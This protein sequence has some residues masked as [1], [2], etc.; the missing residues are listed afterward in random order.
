MN[1][2]FLIYALVDPD[3]KLP[4]YIG[5]S[6]SGLKRPQHYFSTAV[7]K[8][9]TSHK[10]NWI[11]SLFR[12]GKKPIV[13]VLEY[14]ECSSELNDAECFWIAQGRGIGW[15]LTNLTKGGEGLYGASTE[16]REKIRRKMKNRFIS[17]EHR[18]RISAGQ[19][20]KT[21][22]EETRKKSSQSHM[23]KSPSPETR[24]KLRRAFLGRTLSPKAL[25][26]ARTGQK[27]IKRSPG[28]REKIS[29]ALRLRVYSEA[30]REKRRQ[31]ALAQW[32]RVKAEGQQTLT[33]TPGA[34]NASS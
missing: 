15:P 27:G 25:A 6:S 34:E 26:W 1:S 13:H 2:P 29:A 11:L 17:P 32:A 14:F 8:K 20:G 7:L 33:T 16:T 31:F 18:A 10:S 9:E 3:S 12:K 4:R 24:E 22:S 21:V 19:R 5:R 23:G 28:T 30:S